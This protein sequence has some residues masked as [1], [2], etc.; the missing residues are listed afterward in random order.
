[1]SKEEQEDNTLFAK[2]GEKYAEEHMF[3]ADNLN[4]M[5]KRE[6]VMLEYNDIFIVDWGS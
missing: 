1:M 4:D 6:K 3:A 2:L 5:I